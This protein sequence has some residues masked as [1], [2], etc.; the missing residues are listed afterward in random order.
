MSSS[1]TL[2]FV[3]WPICPYNDNY[4][5]TTFLPI[6]KQTKNIYKGAQAHKVGRHQVHVIKSCYHS[7]TN[8]HTHRHAEW[9]KPPQACG[10]MSHPKRG[11]LELRSKP[12][13]PD[14]GWCGDRWLSHYTTNLPKHMLKHQ[15]D[16]SLPVMSSI[17]QSVSHHE[18]PGF[19]LLFSMRNSVLVLSWKRLSLSSLAREYS[20]F[21]L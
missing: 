17:L 15:N 3:F 1:S 4:L 2:K 13:T 5:Y 11:A 20:L 19:F 10:Q 16:C 12:M 8:G 21:V 7:H 14:S 9:R 6:I 18:S